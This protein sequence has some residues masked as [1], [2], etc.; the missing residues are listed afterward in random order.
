MSE[1][2][3]LNIPNKD[4]LKDY[5]FDGLSI[6]DI[7]FKFKK[8]EKFKTFYIIRENNCL[9]LK[10]NFELKEIIFINPIVVYYQNINNEK[11]IIDYDI[12]VHSTIQIDETINIA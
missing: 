5:Y 2:Q 3:A 10:K 8:G 4:P 9:K 1:K 11:K 12:C 6:E 7:I